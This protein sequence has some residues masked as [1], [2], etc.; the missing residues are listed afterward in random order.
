M[1]SCL[2]AEAALPCLVLPWAALCLV[3]SVRESE[4]VCSIRL[5]NTN[6]LILWSY[7]SGAMDGAPLA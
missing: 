5:P 2:A 6:Y 1:F 3:L 4:W 7:L